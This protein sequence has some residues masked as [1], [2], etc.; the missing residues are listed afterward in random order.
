MKKAEL[1]GEAPS[2]A[3]G[4]ST[5]AL[6]ELAEPSTVVEQQRPPQLV[7]LLGTVVLTMALISVPYALSTVGAQLVFDLLGD[8][9]TFTR[10]DFVPYSERQR[11]E[12]EAAE[13]ELAR[14]AALGGG[15]A[16]APPVNFS[17]G[18]LPKGNDR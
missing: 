4:S 18:L 10:K 11:L 2:S 16:P 7:L 5:T 8:K 3:S 13:R 9:I 14:E 12:K 1:T 6:S 17:E 15:I